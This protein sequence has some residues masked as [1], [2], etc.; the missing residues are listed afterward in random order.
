M[1][2]LSIQQIRLA[3]GGKALNALPKDA[4][5][6]KSVLSDSKLV[7]PFSMF[8][9]IKGDRVDGHQYLPDA[10]S[11]GA[12]AALVQE[13]PRQEMPNLHLIGVEDTR[14]AMGKL[15]TFVRNQMKST[16]IAVGGS[17]GKTTTKFFIG[18]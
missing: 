17:N 16:V 12:V 6:V 4:P 2:P 7:E 3:V 18:A 14:R 13:T 1:K 11:R 8:V 15:A 5:P 10:A 9:A